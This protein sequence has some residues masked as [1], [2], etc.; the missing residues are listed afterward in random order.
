MEVILGIIGVIFFASV[1]AIIG[2]ALIACLI[3]FWL[4]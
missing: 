1:L 2:Y 4:G 3:A